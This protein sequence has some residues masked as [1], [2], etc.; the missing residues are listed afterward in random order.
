SAMEFVNE[1]KLNLFSDEIYVFTPKGELRVLPTGATIL[2]FAYD[3]HTAI[4]DTCIGA[5]V[6]NK[7][8]PLSYQLNSGDQLEIITSAKQKPHEE[9]LRM[10]VSARAKQKIKASL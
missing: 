6:N 3:I 4:G 8:V 1:F 2:D 5:K 7:L 10:V 9:W